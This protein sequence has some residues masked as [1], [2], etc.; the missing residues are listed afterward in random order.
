MDAIDQILSD[1]ERGLQPHE[2]YFI[3]QGSVTRSTHAQPDMPIGLCAVYEIKPAI[4]QR[5]VL[6]QDLAADA[7]HALALSER[8]RGF[9]AKH[10]G[11]LVEWA[12]EELALN[13]ISSFAGFTLLF[14]ALAGRAALALAP[15]VFACACFHPK[16]FRP[17]LCGP[18]VVIQMAELK[19]ALS[20]QTPLSLQA[21]GYTH[22]AADAK[23]GETFFGITA[24]HFKQQGIEDAR[25]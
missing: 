3:A 20:L 12:A 14:H 11:V 10:L 2:R 13:C 15:Q 5:R 25:T 4:R 17:T 6:T 24:V 18:E 19:A 23:S 1:F 22:A 7:F 21:H 9:E 8:G 16:N